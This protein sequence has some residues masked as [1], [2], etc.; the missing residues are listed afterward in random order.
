MKL[1]LWLAIGALVVAWLLR[2]KKSPTPAATP[3][4]AGAIEAMIQCSY[5]KVHVPVSESVASSSG[6]AF[7]SEDHR[8]L[9]DLRS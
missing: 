6:A 8:R 1:L 5:C 4:N 9:G 2:G 3:K 7:C